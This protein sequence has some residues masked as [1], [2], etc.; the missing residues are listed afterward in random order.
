MT[1]RARTRTKAG[2]KIPVA[3][4]KAKVKTAKRAGNVKLERK[5]VFAE[6]ARTRN[7]P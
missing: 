5:A 2:G 4:F 6:N 1:L 7:R 3:K